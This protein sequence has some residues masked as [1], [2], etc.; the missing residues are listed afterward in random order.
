ME[1]ELASFACK[2]WIGVMLSLAALTSLPARADCQANGLGELL[3]AVGSQM[4]GNQLRMHEHLER[5]AKCGVREAQYREGIWYLDPK[6]PQWDL[7]LAR[8]YLSRARAQG[9]KGAANALD[10]LNRGVPKE[11]IVVGVRFPSP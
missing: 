11:V 1:K 6:N 2:A 5:A 9:D 8:S 7:A 10:M 4:L 3:L